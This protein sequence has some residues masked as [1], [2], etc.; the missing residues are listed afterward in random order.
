MQTTTPGLGLYQAANVSDIVC[1]E[2]CIM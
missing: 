1:I 2:K